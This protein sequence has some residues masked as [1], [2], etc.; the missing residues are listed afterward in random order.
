MPSGGQPGLSEAERGVLHALCD[1]EE[2]L[3]SLDIISPADIVLVM[4]R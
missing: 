4:K 3:C 1:F 2:F